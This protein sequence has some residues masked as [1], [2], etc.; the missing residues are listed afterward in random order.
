MAS[1]IRRW[2][3]GNLKRKLIVVLC[4]LLLLKMFESSDH[5]MA[6]RFLLERGRKH[7]SSQGDYVIIRTFD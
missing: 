4:K 6:R 5:V 1:S 2:K 3:K 7:R